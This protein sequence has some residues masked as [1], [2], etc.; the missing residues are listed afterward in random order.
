MEQWTGSSKF[1]EDH[2]GYHDQPRSGEVPNSLWW[3]GNIATAIC[4]GT[5]GRR[6][7]LKDPQPWK[8]DVGQV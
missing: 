1:D 8:G 5:L 4:R 2:N 6:R 7:F 3:S